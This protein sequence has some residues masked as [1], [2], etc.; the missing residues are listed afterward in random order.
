MSSASVSD[1]SLDKTL[2]FGPE[3]TTLVVTPQVVSISRS[4]TVP[5]REKMT[6][7]KVV[8]TKTDMGRFKTAI[9]HQ[10]KT[11]SSHT[12]VALQL[13][14]DFRNDPLLDCEC[15]QYE[16]LRTSFDILATCYKSVEKQLSLGDEKVS[17]LDEDSPVRESWDEYHQEVDERVFELEDLVN[18]A[19]ATLKRAN[20]RFNRSASS[21]RES[22]SAMVREESNRHYDAREVQNETPLGRNQAEQCRDRSGDPLSPIEEN[23]VRQSSSGGEP[24]LQRPHETPRSTLRDSYAPSRSNIEYRD[25]NPFSVGDEADPYPAEPRLNKKLFN[26]DLLTFNGDLTKWDKFWNRFKFHVH[27]VPRYSRTLKLQILMSHCQDKA[28]RVLEVG[29]RNG[30]DYDN[31]V[32]TLLFHYDKPKAKRGAILNAIER[33]PVANDTYESI[34]ST[35]CDIKELIDNLS[36]YEVVETDHMCR[37]VRSKFP[38]EMVLKLGRKERK[39]GEDWNTSKLLEKIDGL[40]ADRQEDDSYI[41]SQKIAPTSL[42]RGTVSSVGTSGRKPAENSRANYSAPASKP[43]FDK[44]KSNYCIFCSKNGHRS[45][46]CNRELSV[47]EINDSMRRESACRKC[48][49][50]GHSVSACNA[51]PCGKCQK[52]HHTKVCYAGKP[53]SS[54]NSGNSG[55]NRRDNNRSFRSGNTENSGQNSGA[56]NSSRG[57]NSFRESNPQ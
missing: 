37:E 25:S 14:S 4:E 13:I 7:S 48:L 38:R 16:S 17:P 18:N 50:V 32:K 33:M 10:F 45:V 11:V 21:R 39:S 3:D 49:N 43:P 44:R 40:V 26:L 27:N 57:Q 8:V 24:V 34:S 22:N 47:T 36:L 46:D 9:T 5:H 41:S 53:R 28:L 52:A 6:S 20:E 55:G 19:E 15:A 29:S 1:R 35:F 23:S 54:D 51:P 12:P 56:N 42:E 31:G 30:T 2:D